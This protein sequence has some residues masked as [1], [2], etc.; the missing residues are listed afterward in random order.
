M[1]KATVP[2]KHNDS[3]TQQLPSGARIGSC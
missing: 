3:F 1:V 2:N